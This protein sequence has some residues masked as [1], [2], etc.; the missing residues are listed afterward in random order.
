MNIQ[1]LNPLSLLSSA[2]GATAGLLGEGGGAG[3]FSA[4]LLEQL[5]QLQNSLLSKGAAGD[6]GLANLQ[7]LGGLGADAFSSQSMQDF[8]ALFGKSLP[9]ATK[10][11]QDINLD[12]TMQALA[13]VLQYL[14]GLEGTG[15]AQQT[16]V[17]PATSAN[18]DNVA[19]IA[20]ENTEAANEQAENAAM[21]A[22]IQVQP[23]PVA[24]NG[25][26]VNEALKSAVATSEAMSAIKNSPELLGMD[27]KKEALTAL[28]S[29]DEGRNAMAA[30]GGFAKALAAEGGA[31]QQFAQDSGANAFQS[32]QSDV[33]K[34][35]IGA[36]EADVGLSRM[37]ADIAQ[38]SKSVNSAGQT[39]APAI[40]K[41]LTHP[42][43]NA[44]LGEKLLWM[45][46]QAVPSA[47]IRLNPEHLG[48]ISIK[49]D[50][51]QDQASVVFTAQHAAVRDAIEA[52]IPKLREMLGGQNLNLADVNVSQQQSEQRSGRESFQAAGEQNRG[53]NNQGQG[54]ADSPATDASNTILDEIEAGRAIASNGLLS[55]FA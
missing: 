1:G 35:Q 45:H 5:A 42:E 16:P 28:N 43:W 41:H 11:G 50:V 19:D 38:L 39:Q 24:D 29:A 23:L 2:D 51:N 48:P 32:E 46:K 31:S 6:A 36:S 15:A 30:E 40:E 53:G 47:E 10:L 8:T 52:A 18:Q 17:L 12:D 4:T 49:I 9:T 44:D 27:A 22:G 26:S 37:T 21:L 54:Q 3:V 25:N 55:L 13:D 7:Q 20:A 14:Q 33:P 34:N